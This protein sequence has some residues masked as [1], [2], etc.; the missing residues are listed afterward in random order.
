[1][2]QPSFV[3][4]IEADQ[5]RPALRLEDPRPWVPSRPAELRFPV[6]PGGRSHGSP[7]PDQG[8]ALRLARLFADRLRLR[9]GESEEDVLVGTALLAARRA[10]L[11]G[12][13]PTIHDVEAALSLWGFLDDDPPPGL[14]EVRRRT[15]SCAACDYHAQRALVDRVPEAVIR[16]ASSEITARRDEWPSL[17]GTD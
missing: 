12:R 2:T 6:R 9:S 17:V 5:V 3:P 10:S 11:F 15:F 7:G 14:V 4:I 8:Y 16:L 1:M 13:A